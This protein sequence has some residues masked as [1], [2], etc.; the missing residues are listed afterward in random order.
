MMRSGEKM[1]SKRV[2]LIACMIM[3]FA[4]FCLIAAISCRQPQSIVIRILIS[5]E[6]TDRLDLAVHGT[7]R[8]GSLTLPNDS[9]RIDLKSGTLSLYDSNNNM[10]FYGDSLTVSPAGP[11]DY[12]KMYN[13]LYGNSCYTGNILISADDSNHIRVTAEIPI[14]DY[15]KGV[16]RY[17][18]DSMPE[19]AVKAMTVITK[20]Y[21][22]T[23]SGSGASYDTADDV[24]PYAGCFQDAGANLPVMREVLQ[25]RLVSNG[26]FLYPVL[27]DTNN[28]IYRIISLSQ[29]TPS[30]ERKDRYDSF[31][32]TLPAGIS[33]ETSESCVS[34]ESMRARAAAGHSYEQILSFYFPYAFLLHEKQLIDLS[35]IA[36]P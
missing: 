27:R 13:T 30:A 10:L 23:C 12:V 1:R 9:L 21:A 16:V 33:A 35:D 20:G 3:L 7:V 15:V 34:M 8:S 32:S 4:L 25:D 5:V 11:D 28:G 31:Y 2:V 29:E 22:E 14:D 24:Y 26:S 6:K 19:E 18:A 17:C 36:V